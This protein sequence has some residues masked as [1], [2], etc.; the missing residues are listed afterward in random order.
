MYE[1]QVVVIVEV[2]QVVMVTLPDFRVWQEV[3]APACCADISMTS[4][5]ANSVLITTTIDGDSSSHGRR[6]GR[7]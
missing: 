3:A 2:E 1:R 5:S 4:A 6:S 7:R